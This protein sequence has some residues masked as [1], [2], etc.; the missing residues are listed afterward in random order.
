MPIT[1]KDIAQITGYNVSTV[2]RA[3]NGN[4]R[5]SKQTR[6]KIKA[7]ADDLN[8]EKNNN[9]TSLSTSKTGNIAL[10]YQSSLN[11]DGSKA[12]IDNLFLTIRHELNK[13]NLDPIICE[14]FNFKDN[15]SNSIRLIKQR[16]IDGLLYLHNSISRDEFIY[17]KKMNVP[18]VNIHF[19]PN[20]YDDS[21][22][23]ITD[24]KYGGYLAG[25]YLHSKGCKK[26]L[27][28]AC[29]SNVGNE[30][31]NRSKGCK[32]ALS[33]HGINIPETN[34]LTIDTTF[35]S[36]YQLALENY[37]FI[38][39]FDGIFAQADIVAAGLIAGLKTKDINV[40]KDIKIIGYDDCSFS[41]LFKPY[42]TTIH[43]PKEEITK[44]S[45]TRLISLLKDP[46]KQTPIIHEKIKPSLVIRD[47][48]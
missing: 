1:I 39:Q 19:K 18:I 2:S 30:H 7:V 8:F 13:Q 11:I 41:T 31:K 42:I 5:I 36:G 9:A 47:S 32:E 6:D 12:Y 44:K 3:L 35:D 24:N 22:Y 48:T 10:I 16:K 45:I 27:I 14:A 15:S 23:F 37:N 33:K 43:Q 40:P 28:V 20:F 4:T 34:I 25:E 29:D 26:I 38:K 17:A 21:D 46:N